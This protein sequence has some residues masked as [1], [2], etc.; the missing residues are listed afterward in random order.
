MRE[1][2]GPSTKSAVSHTWT[3]DTR[4]DSIFGTR[5]SYLRFAQELAGLGGDASFHKTEAHAQLARPVIPGV[6][7]VKHLHATVH[8]LT[9]RTVRAVRC[10]LRPNM[11]TQ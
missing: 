1:A 10:T 5:G 8:K 11:A 7:C 2:A 3:R 4:D 6:V 9:S